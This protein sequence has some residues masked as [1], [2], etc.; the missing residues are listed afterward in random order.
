MIVF[1]VEDTDVELVDDQIVE[2][3]R[4]KGLIVPGKSI[5]V[6]N[7]AV[8]VRVTVHLQLASIRIALETLAAVTHDP[9]PVLAA[10][11]NSWEKA[12]PVSIGI[13]DEQILI[14]FLP[15]RGRLHV[16]IVQHYV[17]LFRARRPGAERRAVFCQL[18]SHRGSR[19]NIVVHSYASCMLAI[20]C[21]S[22]SFSLLRRSLKPTGYRASESSASNSSGKRLS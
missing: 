9:K 10:I 22:V 6:A 14:V 19:V 4:T 15:T 20:C 18:R 2:G 7:D 12:C 3:W 21:S 11:D 8:A 16:E 1:G 13:P 5:R 17:D